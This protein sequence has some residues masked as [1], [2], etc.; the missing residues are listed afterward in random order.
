MAAIAS[1]PDTTKLYPVAGFNSRLHYQL[2]YDTDTKTQEASCS[3]VG[4][5][6]TVTTVLFNTRITATSIRWNLSNAVNDSFVNYFN[7]F[8]PLGGSSKVN[9]SEMKVLLTPTFKDYVEQVNLTLDDGTSQTGSQIACL[10]AAVKSLDDYYNSGALQ[11][12]TVKPKGR[13]NSSSNEYIS[14]YSDGSE[15]CRIAFYDASGDYMED[16]DISYTTT[17]GELNHFPIGTAQITVPTGAKSYR[18]NLRN[19]TTLHTIVY[20]IVNCTFHS[21]H[22]VNRFGQVDTMQFDRIAQRHQAKSSSYSQPLQSFPFEDG[23]QYLRHDIQTN[24]IY[25]VT[26]NKLSLE[27]VQ[28][29]AD[30]INTPYAMWEVN[31]EYVP[32]EILD[33]ETQPYNHRKTDFTFT[34]EFRL[35]NPIEGIN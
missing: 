31:G 18:V 9:N 32:V 21:L 8:N 1:Q 3:I 26:A 20:N 29:L 5:S 11:F 7:L 30:L 12:L 14:I 2:L 19:P 13:V 28:W 16:E 27:E 22:F 34:V 17:S 33:T 15:S 10:I 6:E 23:F 25:T 4:E 24:Q 35:S